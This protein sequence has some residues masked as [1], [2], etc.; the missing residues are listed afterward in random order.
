M[1]QEKKASSYTVPVSRVVR[2]VAYVGQHTG[3]G[4]IGLRSGLGSE[5]WRYKLASR[6]DLGQQCIHECVGN[7]LTSVPSPPLENSHQRLGQ[8]G[9]VVFFEQPDSSRAKLACGRGGR[10]EA[11]DMEGGVVNQC[12]DPVVDCLVIGWMWSNSSQG[13]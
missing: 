8:E 13:E 2:M 5:C 7:C 3:T 9:R 11:I 12:E 6:L 1:R 10:I 4:G